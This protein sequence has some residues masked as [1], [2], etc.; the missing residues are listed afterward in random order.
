MSVS[1]GPNIRTTRSAGVDS[2]IRGAEMLLMSGP[3]LS[4]YL[5]SLVTNHIFDPLQSFCL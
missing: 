5:K 2:A 3:I 4:V 1:E